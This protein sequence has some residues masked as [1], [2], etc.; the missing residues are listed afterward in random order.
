LL[1][2]L[3]EE[4]AKGSNRVLVGADKVGKSSILLMGVAESIM[5]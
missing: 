5:I 3:F 2:Q 1:R 4:L